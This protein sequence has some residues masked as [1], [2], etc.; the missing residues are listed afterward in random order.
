MNLTMNHNKTFLWMHHG[1]V[2]NSRGDIIQV[3]LFLI[4]NAKVFKS[5]IK[6]DDYLK[7][8]I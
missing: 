1:Y 3:I 5:C 8:E 6:I 7:T 2:L 4:K